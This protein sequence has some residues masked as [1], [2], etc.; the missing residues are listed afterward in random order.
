[1]GGG[2]D[3]GIVVGELEERA[4]RE[5][6]WSSVRSTNPPTATA[7]TT[8]AATKAWRRRRRRRRNCLV[9]SAESGGRGIDARVTPRQC[10]RSEREA[11][12]NEP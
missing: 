5:I 8:N 11:A 10:G 12:R 6:S 9:A 3:V 1:V 4:P 7:A 2:G